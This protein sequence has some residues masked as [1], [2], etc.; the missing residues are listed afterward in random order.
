MPPPFVT[1]G[2]RPFYA[3]AN[4]SVTLIDLGTR[5]MGTYFVDANGNIIPQNLGGENLASSQLVAGQ[6]WTATLEPF[7]P[8]APPGNDA[9]QRLRRRRSSWLAAYVSNST[10]F[11]FARLFSGPV[12]PTSPAPGTIMNSYRVET[13]NQ[14]ED[15]TQPPPLREQTYS[16]RPLGKD[17]DV[18]RA[19][20]KDTPGPLLV[21][22][23]SMEI[24]V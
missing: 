16:W 12:T 15:S 24:S 18:R 6:P 11:F 21:H 3:F 7:S 9:K 14:G 1:A 8:L 20:I 17:Y 10:G 4:G 23:I 5:M 13:W 19:V 2:K 22:E